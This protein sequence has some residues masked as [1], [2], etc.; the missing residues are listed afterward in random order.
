MEINNKTRVVILFGTFQWSTYCDD[1]YA[2]MKC[3]EACHGSGLFQI[4]GKNKEGDYEELT[5]KVGRIMAVSL[6]RLE[7]REQ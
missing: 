2:K 7:R 5:L 1:D 6:E 3:K 4:E